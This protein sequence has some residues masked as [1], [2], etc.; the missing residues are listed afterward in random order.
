MVG[1]ADIAVAHR[2]GQA[3]HGR[4]IPCRGISRPTESRAGEAPVSSVGRRRPAQDGAHPGHQF[5][6]AVGL[7]DVVVSAHFE[8][9]HGVD[10]RSLGRDHDDGNGRAGPD[11]PAHIDAGQTGQHE[12]EQ[13]QIRF[14]SG[15]ESEGLVAVPGH[16]NVESLA[17]E[18]DDQ[19]IDERLVVLGQQHLGLQHFGC[20]HLGR[21]RLLAHA[22][23][24]GGLGRMRVNVDPSPSRES[25]STWPW[26]L[27]ATWRTIDSPRPV[28]PDSRL[29]PWSTR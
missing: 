20:H 22:E 11:R 9:D 10:L 26:W 1:E 12:I 27:L 4:A 21:R 29:R 18:P 6:E 14:D 16:R 28:P 15:E 3:T 5:T 7:G 2:A 13:Y 17:A 24:S 19:S 23:Y 25:T 8:T